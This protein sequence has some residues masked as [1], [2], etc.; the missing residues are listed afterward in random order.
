MVQTTGSRSGRFKAIGGHFSAVWKST[1]LPD[2]NP[3]PLQMASAAARQSGA[4]LGAV[5]QV[6]RSDI[7]RVP[8][9][10]ATASAVSRVTVVAASAA[11][12]ATSA[13]PLSPVFQLPTE[14]PIQRP[15][16]SMK[17]GL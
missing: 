16:T 9:K 8:G 2:A 11:S 13:A 14:S 15:N 6:A 5:G 4:P 12:L 7:T 10:R 3:R 1:L 17:P